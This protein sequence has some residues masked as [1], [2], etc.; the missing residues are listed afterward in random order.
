MGPIVSD[1]TAPRQPGGRVARPAPGGGPVPAAPTGPSRTAARPVRQ[2]GGRAAERPGRPPRHYA[3]HVSALLRPGAGVRE[4]R[5]HRRYAQRQVLWDVSRL[6]RVRKCGRVPVGQDVT[7]VD[8]AGVAHY[9]GLASCGS[10]WACPVCSAKIRAGR[11]DEIAQGAA[12]WD[13]AGNS[14]YMVTLTAPHDMGMRLGALLPVIADSFRRVIAGR[15]WLRVKAAAGVAGTIRS[16]EITHGVNGWHPHLHV[17]VFCRGDPGAEGLAALGVHVRAQWHKAITGAGYRAPSDAH[18]VVIERCA[19]AAEAGAYIAKSQDT[20]RSPGNELARGDLK[21]GRSGHRTPFEILEDFRWTGD[22]ADRGLWRTY[23]RATKGHQAI[24][25][26]KGLRRLLAVEARSDDELAAAEVGGTPLA[27][28]DLAAWRRVAAV[29]G[30]PA[31]LLDAAEQGGAAA[32]LAELAA[33]GIPAA[34]GPP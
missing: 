13:Q 2:H 5:R 19:S 14:V 11:A 22:A 30:L 6:E 24:T 16:V 7:V 18:G 27:V 9:A 33:R 21:R 17:L 20:G 34:T 15:A 10:I 25:W 4:S 1:G 3:K 28:I 32:V 12:A 29:P 31:L 26:S 23:E 8:N